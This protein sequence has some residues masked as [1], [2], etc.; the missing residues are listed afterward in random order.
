MPIRT[1]IMMA[2]G[3]GLLYLLF[4]VGAPFLL[5]LVVAIFIEPLTAFLIRVSRGKLNRVAAGTISSTVFTIVLL[6]LIALLGARI[7][8]ELVAFWNRV[9][10][11]VGNLNLYFQDAL[12]N[13]RSLYQH[14]PP[15]SAAQLENWLMGL[16]GTLTQAATSLSR[17]FISLAGEIPNL[18]IFFIVFLVAV[19]MFSYS[20][21]TMKASF[22]SIFAE[23]SRKQVEEVLDSLRRS[24]FG[25]LRSQLILSALT[26]VI[27]LSGFLLLG[28]KYPM[29]IALL[30]V[31]V[32]I[33][34][35]LGTGSVL[36]PW[37]TYLILMN[38]DWYTGIG[39]IV[40]FLFITVFRR[41]IEPKVLGD[42]VGIS[43]L[44]ALISLYVGLKL[45][46]VVGVFLG[47]LV[48]IIFMAARKA[49][50]FQL[51]IRL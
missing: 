20:L 19:Y 22:L 51:K 30:V 18:F 37:A 44:A 48:V 15:D 8:S 21:P 39:L 46:G 38:G 9:P 34:P 31:I 24:I 13:A 26:Y 47:P 4:T 23:E 12:N 16:S 2:L 35:I 33:M 42:S 43:A 50:L 17:V 27:T 11:F 5:A 1:L 36:V 25:F 10:E 14:L 3:L 45:A 28:I 32:D 41:I 49:G 6:G 7:V 29:A 40:L